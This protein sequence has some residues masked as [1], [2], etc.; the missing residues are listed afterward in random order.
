MGHAREEE[1]HMLVMGISGGPFKTHEAGSPTVGRFQFHDASAVLLEDG[2]VVRAI[3]GERLNRIKHSNKFPLEAIRFC[4]A[5]YGAKLQDLDYLAYYGEEEILNHSTN[6]WYLQQLLTANQEIEECR[7]A[8][9]LIQGLLSSEFG[10]EFPS[11]KLAFVNHHT[12]HALSAFLPSGFDESLIISLDGQGDNESGRVMVGTKS[13]IKV[14]ARFPVSNSL[15]LFYISVI[16]MLGFQ[17]FDEYKAMGLAPYGNPARFRDIFKTFYTLSADG[18]YKLNWGEIRKIYHLVKPRKQWEE[19]SADHKD[20]AAALQETIEEIVLH[21]LARFKDQTKQRN[22]CIAGGV[23]HN[24]SLNGRILNSGM[25][26]KVFVQPAAHDAGCAYGAALSVHVAQSDRAVEPLKHLY[27]GTDVGNDDQIAAV[28][29]PWQEF[30]SFE[31]VQDVCRRTAGLL[32]EGKI[33]GWVQGQSE[34]GPRA[35]G[36]RSILADARPAENKRVV[37]AMVKKRE[38]FRPFAPSVMREYADK[39]FE[40][41]ADNKNLEYMVFVVKVRPERR[42]LLGAVTHVDGTARVQVV[43][44]QSNKKYWSLLSAFNDLTGVPVL[45]NTSFNNNAEPIVDSVADAVSCFLT[46]KLSC[47]VVGNFIVNKTA[48]TAAT[49]LNLI[50]SLPKH[51]TICQTKGLDQRGKSEVRYECRT[52]SDTSMKH[53]IS[54][55]IFDILVRADGHTPLGELVN[56]TNGD[57]G[58]LEQWVEELCDLWTKRMLVLKPRGA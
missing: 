17:Q 21:I 41:E 9:R 45:L 22:L 3:E 52:T 2:K 44:Q 23:G 51:V 15:G 28:L 27:W 13:S 35:L 42:Q 25:F 50:P 34:F 30:I 10:C 8:R 48:P 43:T 55:D 24:C 58:S 54:A 12:A 56:S 37:N 46:T 18:G 38:A 57:D 11:D 5:S 39:Y 49:Y 53:E 36:N 26:E 19:F 20:I 6:Q 14:L 29:A 16:N 7:D 1:T 4:L 47:L 33:I 40:I 32:A 31:R